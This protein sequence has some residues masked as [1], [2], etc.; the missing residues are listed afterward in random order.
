MSNVMGDPIIKRQI[1]VRIELYIKNINDQS[2]T[3]KINSFT[4]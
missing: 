4:S 1:S 3:L 2:I